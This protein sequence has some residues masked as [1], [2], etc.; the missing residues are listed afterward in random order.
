[1]KGDYLFEADLCQGVVQLEHHEHGI[2]LWRHLTTRKVHRCIECGMPIE[3]GEVVFAPVIN[4][5]NRG[6]RI[7]LDCVAWLRKMNEGET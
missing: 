5:N 4:S 3:K 7:H 6:H 2:Q 1:M